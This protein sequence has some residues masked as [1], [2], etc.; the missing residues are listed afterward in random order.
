MEP[1]PELG[2]NKFQLLISKGLKVVVKLIKLHQ[3][4]NRFLS[5]WS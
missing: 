3:Q 1:F 2:G 5:A 4:V